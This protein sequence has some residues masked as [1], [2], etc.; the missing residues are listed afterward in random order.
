MRLGSGDAGTRWILGIASS[1]GSVT[2]RKLSAPDIRLVVGCAE[3]ELR[4]ANLMGL[5]L[6]VCY[7]LC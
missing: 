1:R 3:V 5:F 4:N 2:K 7:E 6:T